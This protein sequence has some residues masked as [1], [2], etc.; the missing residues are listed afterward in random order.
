M[1][2]KRLQGESNVGQ[3]KCFNEHNLAPS[4][5]SLCWYSIEVYTA[6]RGSG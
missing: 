2:Y 3:W 5:E 1:G 4:G 6:L